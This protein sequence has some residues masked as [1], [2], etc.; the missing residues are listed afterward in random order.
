MLIWV[1]KIVCRREFGRDPA[2]NWF[3]LVSK[4]LAANAWA[5]KQRWDFQDFLGL[6][7]GGEEEKEDS[8]CPMLGGCEGRRCDAGGG[9]EQRTMPVM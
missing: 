3:G 6:R 1:L 8:P 4:M 7:L 9:A 5:E 2:P